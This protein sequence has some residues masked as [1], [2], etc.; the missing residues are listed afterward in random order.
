MK[1]VNPTP[2]KAI[3]MSEPM[4]FQ[5]QN[6]SDEKKEWFL[7]GF[8]HFNKKRNFGNDNDVRVTS[9]T[10][11]PYDHFVNNTVN[12]KFVIGLMRFQSLVK[13]NL[14]TEIFHHK[15][16]IFRGTYKRK[17][18]NLGIMMDAY[19]Q[20]TDIIDMRKNWKIT[21]KTHLSGTV[22]PNSTIIVSIYPI[23]KGSDLPRISGKNVAPVIIQTIKSI[24]DKKTIGA[25][26][27]AVKKPIVKKAVV[28]KAVAKKVVSNK[29]K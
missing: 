17:E 20:Q 21:P 18:L 8:N 5:I 12:E 27:V 1:K 11:I 6:V 2:E 28:K 19:Q 13:K 24:P 23:M 9:V 22:Q 15:Y 10:G 4:V 25:K 3:K 16:N 7:F 29:N 14:Q 26:K